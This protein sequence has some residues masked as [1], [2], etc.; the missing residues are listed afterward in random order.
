M[1]TIEE[2]IELLTSSVLDNTTPDFVNNEI[3]WI[4]EKHENYIRQNVDMAFEIFNEKCSASTKISNIEI[5][6]NRY[7]E[8]ANKSECINVRRMYGVLF[9]YYDAFSVMV[10]LSDTLD[11]GNLK[12]AITEVYHSLR[13][14]KSWNNKLQNILSIDDICIGT[15][16]RL[17]MPKTKKVIA[18]SSAGAASEITQQNSH[19]LPI[20]FFPK[21][22][23][24]K[25]KCLWGRAMARPHEDRAMHLQLAMIRFFQNSI[26]DGKALTELLLYKK[27]LVKEM[28]SH[29]DNLQLQKFYSEKSSSAGIARDSIENNINGTNISHILQGYDCWLLE[30]LLTLIYSRGIHV[31]NLTDENPKSCLESPL[32][33]LRLARNE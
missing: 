3:E 20:L 17:F 15:S 33:K 23:T 29:L 7:I 2:I 1:Q 16:E 6:K 12:T 30:H 22:S 21:I 18:E 24:T 5:Q 11:I 9:I 4:S 25:V 28:V 31:P 8:A 13:N 32:K 14:L 27:N 19:A 10:K 26:T